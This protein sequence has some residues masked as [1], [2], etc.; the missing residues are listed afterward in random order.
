VPPE[1]GSS[2]VTGM[3]N[4]GEGRANFCWT[5]PQRGRRSMWRGERSFMVLDEFPLT[6]TIDGT[7]F[8]FR[9]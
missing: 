1:E 7:K 4:V 9:E 8:Y 5:K 2:P 6:G 3:I